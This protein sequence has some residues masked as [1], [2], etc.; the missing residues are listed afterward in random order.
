MAKPSKRR[1]WVLEMQ[2]DTLPGQWFE[3][4]AFSDHEEAEF[5]CRKLMRDGAKG[6]TFRVRHF[7]K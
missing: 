6:I 3:V 4:D 1:P 7:G 2:S 5:R